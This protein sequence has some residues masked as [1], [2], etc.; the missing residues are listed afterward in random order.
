MESP[1]LM[2]AVADKSRL[3]TVKELL[4]AGF[5]L[6]MSRGEFIVDAVG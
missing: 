5:S 2:N 6:K 3:A 4:I 1:A